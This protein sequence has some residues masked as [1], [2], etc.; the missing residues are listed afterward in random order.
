[1]ELTVKVPSTLKVQQQLPEEKPKTEAEKN[2]EAAAEKLASAKEQ[3][4]RLDAAAATLVTATTLTVALLAALG[5][6]GDRLTVMLNSSGSKAFVLAGVACAVLAVI[7]GTVAQALTLEPD[8][9]RSLSRERR[10]IV[11]GTFLF[12]GALALAVFAASTAF[13]EDGRPTITEVSI[14]DAGGTGA[15]LLFSVTSDGV[16]QDAGLRVVAVWV[17]NSAGEEQRDPFY[18]AFLRPSAMGVIQ[19]QAT[20][21]LPRPSVDTYVRIQAIRMHDP[22]KDEAEAEEIESALAKPD[23]ASQ[24]SNQ[25]D[26]KTAPA[27]V[28]VLVPAAAPAAE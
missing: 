25:T 12:A 26:Q 9:A 16:A 24:C 28:D 22:E 8:A 20:I 1:M 17:R 11:L 13:T 7:C 15:T 6:A 4:T 5:L 3:M 27:C 10:L 21:L 14:A 19:Q 2:A 23:P 18:S